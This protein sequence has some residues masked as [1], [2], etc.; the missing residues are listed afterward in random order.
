MWPHVMKC[1]S[2]FQHTYRN[3]IE[4]TSLCI[5][6]TSQLNFFF[7]N[8][9]EENFLPPFSLSL[10]ICPVSLF[11][12]CNFEGCSHSCN[13]IFIHDHL[14]IENVSL[15]CKD[16]YIYK[17]DLAI[18]LESKIMEPYY[19]IQISVWCYALQKYNFISRKTIRSMARTE[20]SQ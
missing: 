9:N 3:F 13:F 5:L 11:V 6:Q 14:F 4:C 12:W 20:Y 10:S 7:T 16:D 1:C 15:F 19:L 8:C 17:M 18:F 2:E